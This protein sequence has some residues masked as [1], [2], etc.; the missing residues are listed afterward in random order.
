MVIPSNKGLASVLIF[1]GN[2]NVIAPT[3]LYTSTWLV[4]PVIVASVKSVPLPTINWPFEGTPVRPV[5]PYPTSTGVPRQVPE[6]I[7]PRPVILLYTPVTRAV[8]IVPL[9]KFVAFN[10]V[11]ALPDPERVCALTIPLTLT[12]LNTTL[13]VVVMSWG[14][15]KV[16]DPD[17]LEIFT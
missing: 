15:D 16:I 11:I 14:K 10:A 6:T 2:D 3:S 12:L 9:A 17:T 1:C 13:A 8:D 5:P 4:V 7:V